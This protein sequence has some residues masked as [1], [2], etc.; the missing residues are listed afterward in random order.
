[1][2]LCR[3]CGAALESSEARC[4][5][6]V[7]LDRAPGIGDPEPIATGQL[8]HATHEVHIARWRVHH[9][10]ERGGTPQVMAWARQRLAQEGHVVPAPEPAK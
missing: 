7:P 4:V 1:M 6:D 2:P 9:P 8:S 3:V 10:S 5:Y